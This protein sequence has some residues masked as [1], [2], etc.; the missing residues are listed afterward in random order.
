EHAVRLVAC[1]DALART[2]RLEERMRDLGEL[3]GRRERELDLLEFEL[4]E[5]DALGDAAGAGA[6]ALAP[7]S[8]QSQGVAALAAEAVARLAPVAGVDPV[9]DELTER[10]RALAI[11]SED[12]AGDLRAYC[13]R[14]AGGAVEID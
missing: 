13:E 4:A 12:L 11:E 9:L 1:A 3:A 5:I 10:A 14:S 6:E 8:G 7:D 2:R